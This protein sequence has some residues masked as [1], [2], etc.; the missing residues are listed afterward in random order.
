V[1]GGKPIVSI[2]PY[3]VIAFELTILLG[4]LA[5]LLGMLVLG[6]IPRLT[7]S[8]AYDPRFTR[9]KF[10]VAVGCAPG[11]VQSVRDIL[12]ATGAE[13]VRS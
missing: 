13:E 12:A 2:P 7:R 5:T 3:V 8:A 9:D 10:G 4:G 1:T 6:R 11:Q